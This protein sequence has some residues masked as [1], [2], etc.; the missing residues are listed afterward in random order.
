VPPTVSIIV[1]A[2]NEERTLFQCLT[3]LLMQDYHDFELIVVNDQSTDQTLNLI[4]AQEAQDAR[5]RS[6]T[7]TT[8]P[9]GWTG[10]NHALSRGTQEAKGEWLL[11]T[12]ADT[13]HMASTLRETLE[14]AQRQQLDMLSLSPD[15][16]CVGFWEQLLQP[17]IFETLS[18]WF[19][20]QRINNQDDPQAASNG[21][22]IL[23][24][25]SFYNM[26]GGH[27]AIQQSIL[28]DVE[29]AQRTKRAGGKLWFAPAHGKV[30]VRMY[31]TFKEIWNG[32]AKNLY[33][34]QKQGQE[35]LFETS[36]R[37][38]LFDI[39]PGIILTLGAWFGIPLSILVLAGVLLLV[40]G[41]MLTVRWQTLGFATHYAPLY[42]LGSS[43]VLLLLWYSAIRHI[44]NFGV[45]WKGRLCKDPHTSEY[46][47]LK[48]T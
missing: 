15:Q 22:Y 28:E 35:H 18:H 20:Y 42:P 33:L 10:K 30:R 23:I 25:Q 38:I 2:R 37:I 43:L 27:H 3:S 16:E 39:T 1:P 32:W 48:H 26:L 19:S 12:D 31:N 45:S 46:N 9:E 14:F 8:L 17:T 4:T 5:V 13:Y 40:R 21:Q 41:L 24:K 6:L 34:L 29:L 11:F 7:I 47:N 36:M 44:G